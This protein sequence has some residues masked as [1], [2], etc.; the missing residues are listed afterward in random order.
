MHTLCINKI[1]SHEF[2]ISVGGWSQS[3]IYAVV[4]YRFQRRTQD[5]GS[6]TTR[7]PY[8]P[9]R[10]LQTNPMARHNGEGKKKMLLISKLRRY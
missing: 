7:L 1:V 8:A 3:L 2:M 6:V 4:K 9:N 10:N 5:P